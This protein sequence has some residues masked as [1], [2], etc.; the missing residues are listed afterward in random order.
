MTRRVK[1]MN[2]ARSGGLG[3]DWPRL[4]KQ[5][6]L[7][8]GECFRLMRRPAIVNVARRPGPRKSHGIPDYSAKIGLFYDE[9]AKP[10]RLYTP[11]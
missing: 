7:G 5:P 4:V 6:A 1:L 10:N 3:R 9:A 2:E 11:R 8:G